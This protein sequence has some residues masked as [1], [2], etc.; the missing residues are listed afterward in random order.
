MAETIEQ[1]CDGIQKWHW[2][3]V[4]ADLLSHGVLD[5]KLLTIDPFS[6][7]AHSCIGTYDNIPFHLTWL[8]DTFFLLTMD[9]FIPNLMQAFAATLEYDPFVKY[10]WNETITIE[11]D[12]KDPDYR[13][14][15]IETFEGVKNICDLRQGDAL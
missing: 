1:G 13:L 14:L 4:K 6:T 8:K 2:Y 12:K 7:T 9:K 15:A 10:E 11:W 3:N 5:E